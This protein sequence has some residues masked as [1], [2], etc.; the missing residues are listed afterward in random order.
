MLEQ[1]QLFA[2]PRPREFTVTPAQLET[3]DLV[4]LYEAM[5]LPNTVSRK[6]LRNLIERK[7][8]EVISVGPSRYK[9]TAM[10]RLI[11]GRAR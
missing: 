7:L 10:G 9:L 5:P 4:G 11:R 8:V 3:M 1:A 2:M 6:T